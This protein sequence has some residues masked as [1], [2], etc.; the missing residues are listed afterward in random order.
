MRMRKKVLFSFS[1]AFLFLAVWSVLMIVLL[2]L[3]I[4]GRQSR[5][6]WETITNTQYNFS[7]EYPTKWLARTYDELGK[8]GYEPVKLDIYR[9]LLGNFKIEVLF[10]SASNPT[11]EDVVSWGDARINS[12][13]KSLQSRGEDTYEKSPLQEDT[14]NG[15]E[16]LRR[17]YQRSVI[18]SEDIYIARDN[19]MIIITLQSEKEDF[20]AYLEDF[21]RIV[22]SFRPLE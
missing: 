20:D 18:K 5:T 14:I 8:R 9:S 17:V 16:I 6:E 19:D 13:N 12:G 21:E 7:V 15:Q 3:P 4:N 2:Q 11:L 10:Q 1:V 22:Q